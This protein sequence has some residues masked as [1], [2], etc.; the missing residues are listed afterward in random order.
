[1]IKFILKLTDACFLF[2]YGIIVQ[3]YNVFALFTYT[4]DEYFPPYN[5]R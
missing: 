2:G 1:M 5:V 3:L 4:K